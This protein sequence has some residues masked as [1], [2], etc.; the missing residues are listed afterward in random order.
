MSASTLLAAEEDE[1]W[2]EAR[3]R[4]EPALLTTAMEVTKWGAWGC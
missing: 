3:D 2:E 4:R 1:E